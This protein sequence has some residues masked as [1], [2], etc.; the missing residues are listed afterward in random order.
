MVLLVLVSIGAGFRLKV[1]TVTLPLLQVQLDVLDGSE[2][3]LTLPSGATI[4]H[5]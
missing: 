1:M 2:Y 5:R 4:G 3:Q